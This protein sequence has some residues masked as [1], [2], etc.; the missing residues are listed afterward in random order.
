MTSNFKDALEEL[1]L[2]VTEELSTVAILNEATDD[3]VAVPTG[4]E[5]AEPDDNEAADVVEDWNERRASVAVME[6]DYRNIVRALQKINS[7]TYGMCEISG[8]PIE[9]DRLVANPAART[10]IA[11]MNEEAQLSL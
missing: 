5:V 3:W 7:G 4:T 11:H 2:K 10:C 1:L 9:Y 6:T 8:E